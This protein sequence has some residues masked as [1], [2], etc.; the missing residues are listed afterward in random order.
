MVREEDSGVAGEI[1]FCVVVPPYVENHFPYLMHYYLCIIFYHLDRP[2]PLASTNSI[3]ILQQQI[4]EWFATLAC[5]CYC[6]PLC[7]ITAQLLHL[8][9]LA[10]AIEGFLLHTFLQVMVP[11]K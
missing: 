4:I 11:M 7:H 10:A 1:S 6:S 9:K 2:L 5:H 3:K 8:S